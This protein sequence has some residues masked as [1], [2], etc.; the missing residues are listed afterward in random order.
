MLSVNEEDG[1]VQVCATLST[2]EYIEEN[3]T[4]KLVT[5]NKTGICNEATC[6]YIFQSSLFNLFSN[7]WF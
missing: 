5:D 4:I 2:M 1:I 3:V 6:N 7:G